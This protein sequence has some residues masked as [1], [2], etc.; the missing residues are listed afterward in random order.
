MKNFFIVVVLIAF[1][2]CTSTASAKKQD[3]TS[4]PDVG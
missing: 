2:S 3:A 1:F 4:Q